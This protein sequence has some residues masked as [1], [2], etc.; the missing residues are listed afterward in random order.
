MSAE[1]EPFAL[2]RREDAPVLPGSEQMTALSRFNAAARVLV[3][4]Q[5]SYEAAQL[6]YRDAVKA[7]SDEAC[8]ESAAP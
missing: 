7:L 4:A 6:E 8:K 1:T 5:K 3:A 2:K